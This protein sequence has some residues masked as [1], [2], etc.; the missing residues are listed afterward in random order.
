MERP[1]DTLIACR[2]GAR[3]AP[4]RRVRAFQEDTRKHG[5]IIAHDL[6]ALGF[7]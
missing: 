4:A 6:K 3:K 5:S 1:S 7:G 2:R